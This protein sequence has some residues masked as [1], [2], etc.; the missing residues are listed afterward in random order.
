MAKK[1]TTTLILAIVTTGLWGGHLYYAEFLDVYKFAVSFTIVTISYVFF[2][3]FLDA[4][5][6]KKVFTKKS[7]YKLRKTVSLIYIILTA[8]VIS[9]VWITDTAALVAVYGFV[10]AAIAFALQDFFKNFVGGIIILF[11]QLYRVGDRVSLHGSV[12]DVIDIDLLYTELLEIQG[13][14]HGDQPTGRIVHVPNGAVLSENV[15]NY[16]GDNSFIWDEIHLPITF[17]SNWR[18]AKS[19]LEEV[20]KKFVSDT[21]ILAKKEMTSMTEKYFLDEANVEPIVFMKITDNWISFYGRY[22]VRARNRR[23]VNSNIM[24]EVLSRIETRKDITIAS[25]TM[26]ITAVKAEK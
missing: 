14:V 26:T 20:M 25:E 13:W 6:S 18:D 9:R 23:L 4:L 21:S 8:L 1:I 22:V 15:H 7:R 12:G 2:K 19:I 17:E 11:K 5:I 24:G 10:A 16:T 3:L